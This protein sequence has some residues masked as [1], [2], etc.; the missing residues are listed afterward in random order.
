M[1]LLQSILVILTA[2]V[3]VSVLLSRPKLHRAVDLTTRGAVVYVLLFHLLL[4]SVRYVGWECLFFF[5][6]G[7]ILS[8][9]LKKLNSKLLVASQFLGFMGL[10]IHSV[11]DGVILSLPSFA[12]TG[13]FGTYEAM[14]LSIVLHTFFLSFFVWEWAQFHFGKLIGYMWL[15]AIA[16]L[17]AIGF[18]LP[19][20]VNLQISESVILLHTQCLLAG[21]LISA[22]VSRCY[23]EVKGGSSQVHNHEHKSHKHSC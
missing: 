19:Y 20:Q 11:T 4:P 23:H 5:A 3:F 21:M 17:T 6:G 15:V 7:S 9:V 18:F 2:P 16:G 13:S 22:I 1:F 10:C 14:A 8:L 12:S